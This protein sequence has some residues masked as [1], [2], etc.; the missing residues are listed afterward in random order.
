MALMTNLSI[1][2]TLAEGSSLEDGMDAL[3][4]FWVLLQAETTRFYQSKSLFTPIQRL[5]DVLILF[6]EVTSL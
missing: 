6:F 1:Q 5:G 4:S 2:T 3:E